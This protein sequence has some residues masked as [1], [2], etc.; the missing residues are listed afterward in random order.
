MV[1]AT[2]LHFPALDDYLAGAGRGWELK[3]GLRRS[4][5]ERELGLAM[6]GKKNGLGAWK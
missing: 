4:E 2:V 6:W 3:L 1:T 5:S